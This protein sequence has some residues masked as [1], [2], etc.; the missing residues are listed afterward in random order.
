MSFRPFLCLLPVVFLAACSTTATTSRTSTPSST[1]TLA[2]Q[3]RLHGGQQPV[4]GSSLQ[5][6]AVGLSGGGS[7]ATPLLSTPGTSDG[8][9]GF[10]ITGAYSCPTDASEVY[11]LAR[12]GNPGLAPGTNNAAITLMAALG[13]CGNLS[14]STF[15]NVDEV[16]TVALA[17]TLAPFTYST[18]AIGS[19][20]S[21][22]ILLNAAFSM[23][24]RF[25]STSNGTS[26]G[27]NLPGGDTV[28]V[29]KI[30]TLANIMAGCINSAGGTAGDS[31][32]CG[33]LFSLATAAGT[34]APAD[35]FTAAVRI[36]DTPALNT[37]SLFDTSS[38]SA[39]FQ[40]ALVSVPSDLS[41]SLGVPAG[42]QPSAV[43]A[44]FGSSPVGSAALAQT[45][46]LSNTSTSAIA[47]SS[48]AVTGVFPDDFVQTNNCPAS[49]AASASCAVQVTFTPSAASRRVAALAVSNSSALSPLLIGLSGAGVNPTTVPTLTS[50]SPA[51]FLA[52]SGTAVVTLLGTGFTPTT[53]AYLN[54]T[55]QTTAYLSP[56]SVSFVLNSIY[57][58]APTTLAFY[59]TNAVGLSNTILAAV[60]NPAPVLTAISPSSVIAGS[61]TFSLTLTGTNF[62]S[63]STVLINGISHSPYTSSS[64][65]LSVFVDAT[66]VTT[67][68]SLA[69][70][71]VSPSPGG[72]TSAPQ[73]LQS[74]TAGNRVQTLGYS[75]TDLVTDPVRTMVYASVNSSSSL[76]PNSLVA[77][78]PTQGTVVTTATLNGM[79]DRIAIS[80]DG[81]Y[82]YVSLPSTA[83]IARFKLPALTPDIR[84]TIPA[85]AQDLKVAP[86]QPHTLAV[87]DID[88]SQTSS[89][90][91][92]YDDAV[93]AQSPCGRLLRQLLRHACLGGDRNRV[94]RYRVALGRRWRSGVH[95]YR[96]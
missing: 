35:T 20:P 44:A 42:L 67:P 82:L 5:L 77:V 37:Q 27:T 92:V 54:G 6:Y 62:G 24:N 8:N 30:N 93:A 3:G 51:S 58:A 2:L 84:W 71:V 88:P 23:A 16:T 63:H 83:E 10:N 18:S 56:Q 60:V 96:R 29:A 74:L 12:G 59:V 85:A 19:T 43:T 76:S 40:P 89:T 66:E 86:G 75:T 46:T 78:D 47:L 57:V 38:A 7:A 41:I 13:A 64:S 95:P 4:S 9:G 87:S 53:T 61:P 94:V 34:S 31:S 91:R 52:G 14:A 55:P 49:L 68:G 1:G 28:P 90:V 25:A 45:I 79:P 32:A 81:A 22:A 36:A 33:A 21:D 26:P 39:P 11:L 69:V 50:A 80:D 73:Q 15:V 65:T 48:L 70:T 72:G 17:N